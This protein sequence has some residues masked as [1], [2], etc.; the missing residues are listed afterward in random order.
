[1]E[2]ADAEIEVPDVSTDG[3]VWILTIGRNEFE[4]DAI[5]CCVRIEHVA[6]GHEVVVP[7]VHL[8]VGKI[9]EAPVLVGVC[10]GANTISAEERP[11]IACHK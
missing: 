3:F 2:R 8:V 7:V 11:P 5:E 9:R 6:K 10:N 1:M 4:A